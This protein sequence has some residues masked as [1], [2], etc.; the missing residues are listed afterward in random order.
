VAEKCPAD[1]F[2]HN[3]NKDIPTSSFGNQQQCLILSVQ[4][5]AQ[6]DQQSKVHCY[7]IVYLGKG[8]LSRKTAVHC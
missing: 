2:I 5:V 1:V 7:F 4:E 3:T 6:I 8:F